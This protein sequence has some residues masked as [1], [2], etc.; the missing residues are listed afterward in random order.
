MPRL[1]GTFAGLDPRFVPCPCPAKQQAA[2]H[3]A[4]KASD[5]NA[6]KEGRTDQKAA[7]YRRDRRMDAVKRRDFNPQRRTEKEADE[8]RNDS[9][10]TDR[11][12][13]DDKCAFTDGAGRVYH[14]GSGAGVRTVVAGTRGAAGE[15]RQ[16][17]R[18][19]HK[20]CF[21]YKYPE[22]HCG[23]CRHQPACLRRWSNNG[24]QPYG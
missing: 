17:S 21:P 22:H 3:L 24:G 23:K 16:Q 14:S 13:P 1:T 5:G 11:R 18:H 12:Q 6:G 20:E 4:D 7:T 10:R 2:E 15:F 8:H 19:R 9:R